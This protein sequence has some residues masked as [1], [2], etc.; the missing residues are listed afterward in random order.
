MSIDNTLDNRLVLEI[1]QGCPRG[2]N[3]KLEQIDEDDTGQGSISP[4]DISGLTVRVEIKKA[5]Y[6]NL[7]A[8]IKKDITE[9]S[10]SD[11]GVI[12]NGQAGEFTIQINEEESKKLNPGDYALVVCLV[13]GE[14]YTHLS[15][16][17]NV[18]ALYRVCYQ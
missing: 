17:G 15:G 11:V 14:T 3:F 16:D 2:F 13:D 7:P 8:L 12:T 6:A 5:P 1:N 18:Y 4:L 10:E 9:T